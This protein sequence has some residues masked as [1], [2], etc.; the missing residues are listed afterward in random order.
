[1]SLTKD[2]YAIEQFAAMMLIVESTPKKLKM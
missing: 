2:I 1:M